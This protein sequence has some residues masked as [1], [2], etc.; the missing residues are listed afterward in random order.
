MNVAATVLVTAVSPVPPAAGSASHVFGD[1]G[2]LDAQAVR[3]AVL[4]DPRFLAECG[5]DSAGQVLAPPPDHPQLGWTPPVG[6]VRAAAS[7]AGCVVPGCSRP[8]GSHGLCRAHRARQMLRGISVDEFAADPAR[9]ALARFGPCLVAACPRDRQGGRVTYCEPHQSRWTRDRRADP[10]LDEARWRRTTS[11]VVLTGRVSL[12]GM[13]PL[14]TAQVLYGLQQRTRSGAHTRVQMLRMV[15]EDLRHA[16]ADSVHATAPPP[17]AG[18]EKRT[19]L[20]ALA[21]HAALA[22]GDPETEKAKDVWE[23]AVF[24]LAGR[25]TFTT[26]SQPWLRETAKRWA[27]DELPRRRGDNP[28][29]VMRGLVASV[30]RLSHSLRGSRTDRGE[31]PARLGRANIESFLHR[32]SY[33]VSTGECSPELRARTCREVKRFLARIRA[34]GLTRPGGPAAGLGCDF[35]LA[36]GDI[37]AEP[38]RG[39]PCRDL[40]AAIMKQLCEQLPV[41]ER[42]PSGR[43]IRVAVELLMDTGRRP[44][45]ILRLPVDCLTRD[46]DNAAVLI[47]DNHKRDRRERRLPI[48]QATAAVITSQQQRVRERF[49]DTPLAELVLLPS[50]HANPTGAKSLSGGLLDLR[51]RDWVDQLPV[52]RREDG[53]EF[54]RAKIVPYAYRHTYA[55]RHADAGIAVDVLSKLLDHRTLEV[56]RRYYR[57]GERP[58][59]RRR[60]RGH[61]AQLRPARQPDLARRTR[62]ARVRARPLRGRRR[63]RPL[64]SLHRTRQRR[65]RRRRLPRPVPLRRLR[66][67]PHRHLA[68]ARADRLPRGPAAHPGTAG[69]HHRRDRRVG[70]GGRHPHRRGDHPD[71]AA[72]QPHHRRHRRTRPDPASPDH[73]RRR[74]GAPPPRRPPRRAR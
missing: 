52:L 38:E 1:V 13:P 4:V 32:M 30:A 40:P 46:P 35:T 45:E 24:G 12:A 37:P 17:G 14:I 16:Q 23:L 51:H 55:Q 72:D 18:R 68:P 11:P 44:A 63:R 36:C 7:V 15:V 54:D 71:P 48:S 58:P 42:G 34:L 49:P 74:G 60:R 50:P 5:W 41:L 28:A 53:T 39:E 31:H 69:R 59:P 20:T 27:A 70:P 56:T 65:G 22:L 3:L 8:P 47:Y 67:L 61:R 57:V 64:R 25:L 43:E 9:R 6:P 19:V 73:R 2:V 33:L 29:H 21:H 66:P 62:P 26:I 10:G